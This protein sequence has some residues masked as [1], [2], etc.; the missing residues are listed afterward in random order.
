MLSLEELNH[1]LDG[2]HADRMATGTSVA[3]L[4][5]S[6]TITSM[7]MNNALDTC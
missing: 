2:F 1:E 4:T 3:K 7:S 5:I 6:I